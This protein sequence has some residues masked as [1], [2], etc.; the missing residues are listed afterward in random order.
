[1]TDFSTAEVAKILDLAPARIR[2][3]ARAGLLSPSK[4]SG[5]RLRFTF[6]DLLLLKTTKDLLDA[7][8]PVKR[9]RRLLASLRRQLPHDP[10]LTELTIY[11]DGRRIVAWDGAAR[12]QPDSGQ[13][14]FNFDVHDV[15]ER[16]PTAQRASPT[17]APINRPPRAAA[18]VLSAQEWFALGL[19]LEAY[20]PEEAR[21]AYRQALAKD[22]DLADAH[23]NLG[24]LYQE[25]GEHKR[26]ESHYRAAAGLAEAD[27]VPMFN[28]GVLY[29]GLER[30]EDAIRAY[31][32]ALERD[33]NF[34]DAH[35]N[36]GLVY[37]AMGRR[38]ETMTHLGR[39]RA[40]YGRPDRRG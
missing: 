3:C 29:D 5:S 10:H 38:P 37:D 25:A 4:R 2:A 36:L 21:Q 15:T 11:A 31:R 40:L 14:L 9:I 7:G 39:A 26:A 22:R 35:Y 8:I 34:A 20:S 27:P 28:L 6:H 33:P 18:P 1:V 32:H 13:F 17:V 24:R 12:W 16:V 30:R 23:V 19:E